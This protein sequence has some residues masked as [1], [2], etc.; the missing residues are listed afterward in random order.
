MFAFLIQVHLIQLTFIPLANNI[1]LLNENVQN[2]VD[3]DCGG[4]QFFL[5]SPNSEDWKK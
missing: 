4:G 2:Q 1:S 3:E 5:I